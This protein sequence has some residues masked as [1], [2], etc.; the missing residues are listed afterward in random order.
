MSAISLK[1]I[2]AAEPYEAYLLPVSGYP[3]QA[4]E[5]VS[6]NAFLDSLCTAA[7]RDDGTREVFMQLEQLDA[8]G[9]RE[10]FS[11]FARSWIPQTGLGVWVDRPAPEKWTQAELT[12]VVPGDKLRPIMFLVFR[13]SKDQKVRLDARRSMLRFGPV[14]EILTPQGNAYLKACSAT[15]RE[16]ITDPS[17]TCFPYYV[18]LIEAKSIANA[19]RD[20]LDRWFQ[21]VKLYVRESFEDKGILIASPVALSELFKEIGGALGQEGWTFQL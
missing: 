16:G 10:A 1:V 2:P 17:Y 11:Q 9:C 4:G 8:A 19:K 20:Q 14:L 18:G 6:A 12:D 5:E 3:M 21:G 7:M 13:V 15:F